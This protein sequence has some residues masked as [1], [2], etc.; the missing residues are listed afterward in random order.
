MDQV[1]EVENFYGVYLLVNNN[2]DPKYNGRCYVGFTVN[3]TRRINQHNKGNKFG[4]AKH[5]TRVPGP[6][7]M[8]LIVHDFPDNI[9]A[10][11]FEWAWQEP[12]NSRRLKVIDSI[13]RK[14]P[15]ESW[16]KYHFRILTEMINLPPW[17]RL[18]LKVRWLEQD[19]CTDFPQSR[20][21]NHM[22]ICFGAIKA[23][24]KTIAAAEQ[25]K[26]L[27]DL[28]RKRKECHLCL[29]DI[30]NLETDR[31]L[32]INPK[33]KLVAH[34]KCLAKMCL[35]KNHYVPIRGDCPLCEYKFLWNDI[36]RKKKGLSVNIAADNEDE[37]DYDI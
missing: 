9:S 32:C 7:T 34:M 36:I 5:T 22:I 19:F 20:F 30:Q 12:K 16:F 37:G 28:I 31:V 11:R 10:L 27:M 3:P 13:Q 6:W 26:E 33:C 15:S 17:N 21:P 29:N 2:D 1:Q 35:E 25:S 14:K 24:K 18:P 4:G 23:R 8:V